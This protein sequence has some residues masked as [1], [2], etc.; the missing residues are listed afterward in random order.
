[1]RIDLENP[2]KD[3]YKKAYLR[4]TKDGRK[5]LDLYNSPKD[6]T[7]VSYAR[8]LM[9]CSIGRLLTEDEEVDHKDEDRTNDSLDNLQI[10]S[11]QEH[12]KKTNK[13]RSP[14]KFVLL[15]CAFCGCEFKKW[16]NQLHGR[17]RFFCSRSCN[18]KNSR[19]EGWTGKTKMV[20]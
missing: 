17:S 20:V 14:R 5:L 19:L 1:M 8:Y 12:I 15:K 16:E 11:K 6:R 2:Y 13:N 3:L 7:T 18:A 9:S 10:L 4:T